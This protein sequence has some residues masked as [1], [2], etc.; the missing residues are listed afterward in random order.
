MNRLILVS[1]FSLIIIMFVSG[2]YIPSKVVSS[3]ASRTCQTG[4]VCS[5]ADCC[6]KEVNSTA[7][8]CEKP[9]CSKT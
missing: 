5:K 2:Q 1:F 8:L 7:V 9:C 4:M 6:N 3:N